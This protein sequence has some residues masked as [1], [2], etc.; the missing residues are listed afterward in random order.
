MTDLPYQ[1]LKAN[2]P[3][4]RFIDHYCNPGPVQYQDFGKDSITT[5]MQSLYQVETDISD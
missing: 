4:W 1:V 3:S 2:E 5:T